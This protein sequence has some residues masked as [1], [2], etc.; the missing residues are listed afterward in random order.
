ML[1][2]D[3]VIVRSN[4]QRAFYFGV[5]F[6]VGKY[7]HGN[8][9][10][11]RT[12]LDF[13]QHVESVLFGHQKIKKNQVGHLIAQMLHRFF[14]VVSDINAVSLRFKIVL[15]SADQVFLVFRD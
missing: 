6:K 12:F 1:R 15:K 9:L 13:L 11:F 8:P 3:A 4:F 10:E 14:A 7:Q 5:S 2:F